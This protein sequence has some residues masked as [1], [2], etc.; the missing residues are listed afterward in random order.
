MKI[1]STALLASL[2]LANAASAADVAIIDSGVDLLHKDLSP[3]EWLNKGEIRRNEIDDDN[4]GYID[5]VNGWN[6]AENNNQVID[7]QYLGQFTGDCYKFFEIQKKMLEG[8]ATEEEKAWVKMKLEDQTFI[9]E[10]QKFGNFVHG[11]HVAGIAA[12]NEN[13]SKVMAVKII[14]TEV[15]LPGQTALIRTFDAVGGGI[16]S[17]LLIKMTLNTFADQQSQ[18]LETVG[19]YVGAGKAQVA[20]CSFGTSMV[21]ART[22]VGTFLV[23]LLGRDPTADEVETYSIYFVERLV[24]G[25]QKMTDAAPDTLFVMAAGNDGTN[26]DEKPVSPANVKTANTITVAATLHGTKIASFS[27][28]GK[29]M[30]DVAAPGVGIYSTIPG[31][32]Y[33]S[34]S[35]TSQAAPFVT[36]VA[37]SIMTI[38]PELDV[39]D[40][41][42]ILMETVDVK[43]FLKDSVAA[44]GIVN[45]ARARKAGEL[46]KALPLSDAIKLSR[47]LVADKTDFTVSSAVVN[48][49]DLFVL[50]LP[51]TVQ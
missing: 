16:I 9:A 35:G 20:N 10:L 49:K 29:K 21:Q 25:S 5:D 8:I 34:M 50:P 17:D 18:L 51:S 15:K 45:S 19:L 3:V 42:K 37:N 1:I 33:L 13:F 7:Y 36:N 6:F 48:E 41:K 47:T 43:D 31:N 4:N 22:L 39:I 32:E 24:E 26:N 14:P 46:S 40:V 12:K 44:S 23:L 28:Y 27:N 2:F 38:N 30:V 11:T